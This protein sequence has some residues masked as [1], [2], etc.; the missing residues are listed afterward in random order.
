MLS[1]H[2]QLCKNK[3]IFLYSLNKKFL[4]RFLYISER[5]EERESTQNV[6]AA[7]GERNS[8]ADLPLSVE[9][10]IGLDSRTLR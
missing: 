5:E 8:Q 6:G 9:T 3:L 7:E 4:K 1:P 10:H 2:Q